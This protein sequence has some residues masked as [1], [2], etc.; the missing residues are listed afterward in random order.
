MIVVVVEGMTSVPTGQ[1]ADTLLSANF[2]SSKSR[3]IILQ[4][5]NN[6]NL[7]LLRG[8]LASATSYML[9]NRELQ[10]CGNSVVL[11]LATVREEGI[12]IVPLENRTVSRI[13]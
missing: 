11:R 6:T 7:S 1:L 3:T 5:V 2:R 10:V 13:V 8:G 9:G 12:E 4:L